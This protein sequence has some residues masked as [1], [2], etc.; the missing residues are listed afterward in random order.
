MNRP[1]A[2][3]VVSMTVGITVMGRRGDAASAPNYDAQ[4]VSSALPGAIA[5]RHR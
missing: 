4:S 1:L 2:R 5:F 3:A